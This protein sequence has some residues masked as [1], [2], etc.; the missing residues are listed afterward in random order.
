[1]VTADMIE[2]A[3]SHLRSLLGDQQAL[4]T[5]GIRGGAEFGNGFDAEEFAKVAGIHL[6][7]GDVQQ[8]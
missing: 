4:V 5:V 8:D 1:M 7:P 6:Q 3:I 2:S